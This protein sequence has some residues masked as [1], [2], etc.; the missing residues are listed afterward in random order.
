M[1]SMNGEF[2]MRE[3]GRVNDV[4]FPT[5][6]SRGSGRPARNGDSALREP[7]RLTDDDFP[8]LPSRGSGRPGVFGDSAVVA[9]G[10]VLPQ[11]TAVFAVQPSNHDS[12]TE[13]ASKVYE[14]RKVE[15]SAQISRILL[16]F[17]RFP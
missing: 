14:Y 16:S 12:N 17:T 9:T 7:G 4:D 13:F 15:V 2:S 6:S 5:L 1:S 8:A 10:P 3:P 11:P